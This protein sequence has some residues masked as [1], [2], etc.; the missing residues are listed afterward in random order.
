MSSQGER[1]GKGAMR[2]RKKGGEGGVGI[3]RLCCK[4]CCNRPSSAINKFIKWDLTFSV[5]LLWRRSSFKIGKP[6]RKIMKIQ[7]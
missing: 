4:R 7:V 6:K 5:A 2:I 3:S 1:G